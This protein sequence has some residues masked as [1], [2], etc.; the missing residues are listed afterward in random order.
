MDSEN[1][2]T[3]ERMTR[4]EYRAQMG[5]DA[6]EQSSHDKSGDAVARLTVVQLIACLLVIGTLFAVKKLSPSGFETVRSSY[7]NAM[8]YSMD[9]RDVWAKIKDAANFVFEPAGVLSDE[10]TSEA[11]SET[12]SDAA[13]ETLGKG[14]AELNVKANKMSF[15]PYYTTMGAR[16]PVSGRIS[17]P[18][19]RREDPF[20]GEESL[21]SG[22]D[23]AAELGSPVSAAFY[24]TVTKVG[25][26]DIAGKYILLSHA[27]GLETFYCHCSE[28]IA[29]LGAVIRQ[30]ETIALVGSTGM[31]TGP[32][33]HFEVRIN[34]IKYDPARLVGGMYV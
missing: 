6:H 1:R 20:T 4:E 16:K 7:Q 23:I 24:G 29:E 11:E 26:D 10:T 34:G 32:H 30:G 19:G 15:S 33:L 17:S 8:Q 28:I 14:S 2:S 22:I 5:L 21:H 12:Y 27:D 9:A 31:A 18:F 25:E 3:H 13:D